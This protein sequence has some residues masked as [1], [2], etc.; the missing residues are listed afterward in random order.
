V[1]LK[2]ILSEAQRP[3]MVTVPKGWQRDQ[4][5]A[6]SY[7]ELTNSHIN[8][9]DFNQCFYDVLCEVRKVEANA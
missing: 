1:V 5:I 8:T 7:Q 9:T 3:G 6:G 4:F 2:T